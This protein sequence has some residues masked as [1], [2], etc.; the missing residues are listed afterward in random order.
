MYILYY[1]ALFGSFKIAANTESMLKPDT[2]QSANVQVIAIL[3]T[4]HMHTYKH[5]Y[6]ISCMHAQ[7]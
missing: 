2:I 7:R 4:K 1:L 3:Y 6:S 5:M